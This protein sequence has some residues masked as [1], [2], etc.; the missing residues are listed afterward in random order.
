MRVL[1]GRSQD[2]EYVP[3]LEFDGVDF[4]R[5]NFSVKLPE[6]N[7]TELQQPGGIL[8]ANRNKSQRKGFSERIAKSMSRAIVRLSVC[9]RKEA[10]RCSNPVQ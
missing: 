1:G 8:S 2:G 10:V 7:F 4:S 5:K 6:N 3:F 9:E